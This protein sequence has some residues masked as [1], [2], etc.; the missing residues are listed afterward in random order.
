MNTFHLNMS[1]LTQR[2]LVAVIGIP[3]VCYIILFKP[4]GLLG[5]TLIFALLAVHEFYGLAK[6]KGFAPQITLG[7]VFTALTVIS[8]A[9]FQMVHAVAFLHLHLSLAVLTIYLLP[10][11]MIAGVLATLTA[12]LFKGYPNPLMQISVTIAGVSYV[13]FGL[14]AFFGIREM[15]YDAN[16]PSSSSA[17]FLIAMLASIWICDTAAFAIGRKFGRHK[18]AERVSPNK[19][20]EGAIAG[21]IAA[22]ATW[23]IVR[24]YIGG[25]EEVSLSTAIAMGIIVGVFGQ[26]GD[27]AESMLKRD[28][29]V[30]DSSTL[31][32]GHG[33][34]LDRI[35]SILFVA[36]LTYFYLQ[37]F[38]I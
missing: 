6:A 8:F 4:F 5:L 32:P 20:W 26:V 36:P 37:L 24:V 16:G 31:I 14:G 28:A 34:V 13:G 7:M 2:I 23:L 15:F 33:G 21:L 30:K 1:N 25:L 12:E 35:D 3:I 9:H 27:F 38:G 11:I 18:I 10:L 22:I 17:F 19:T 29:G